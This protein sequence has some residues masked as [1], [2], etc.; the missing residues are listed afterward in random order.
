MFNVGDRVA[1]DGKIYTVEKVLA[2]GVYFLGAEDSFVDMVPENALTATPNRIAEINA[3][4]DWMN[5]NYSGCDWC[6]GGGDEWM[7]ELVDELRQ[8]EGQTPV[9]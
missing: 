6:C 9:E 5:E 2:A 8:L 1:Y 7:A 4:I 3:I